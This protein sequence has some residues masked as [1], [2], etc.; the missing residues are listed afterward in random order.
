MKSAGGHTLRYLLIY[1]IWGKR[2]FRAPPSI[3]SK[4][5]SYSSEARQHFKHVAVCGSLAPL[6]IKMASNLGDFPA[7]QAGWSRQ[8]AVITVSARVLQA[9]AESFRMV[10]LPAVAAADCGQT[11]LT[12]TGKCLARICRDSL[13]SSSWFVVGKCE[14][15][16]GL[17]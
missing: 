9:I 4:R 10:V 2:S 6:L 15:E 3:F 14:N 12:T 8:P 17:S 7:P 16:H 11:R 13:D 1:R 5:P